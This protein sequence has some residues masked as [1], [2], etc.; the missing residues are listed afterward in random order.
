MRSVERDEY[1]ERELAMEWHD[2]ALSSG[3]SIPAVDLQKFDFVGYLRREI[4][5][6]WA[7]CG[8]FECVAFAYLGVS[9]ALIVLFAEN[10]AHPARLIGM[11]VLVAAVI[12]GLCRV[13]ARIAGR[14][15][16]G[17]AEERGTD[18]RVG[19]I[20]VETKRGTDKSVCPT[21]WHFWRHWY[22]HLYFLFCFEELG[23][24]VHLVRPG[25]EDAKLIAFD[26][27]LT[28]VHP[29]VWLEQFATP[30]RNDFMQFVYLTYFTYLL[31]VGGILY[32]RRDWQGYWAVMTYSAVGYAIG[33]VI[34]IFF[35][36]ESPWFSMA[37]A[38]HGELRGGA[39]T[40]VINFIEHY[41]RV[42]GAAFPSEHVAGA[43]AATWGAW[44]H[45]RW[46]F[47]V[48]LP[49]VVC[50]CVS[51]I[52]GRYHYVADIFGGMITGTL[53]YFIGGWLMERRRVC[54]TTGHST[55]Q[56]EVC[57]SELSG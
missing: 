52:W 42:R 30:G 3:E 22:P 32:Y 31:V 45:R 43:V 29:T 10:L 20:L 37:G 18:R 11:Q 26:H 5:A 38:W 36:I 17:G 35:P 28:G 55:A 47:W 21:L 57:A 50:M 8:V 56:T 2:G 34:A 12:L 51:T 13:E 9:S 46:L 41:G 27:W 16:L 7:A 1:R 24:L 40:S 49:L 48:M 33:Y 14:G 23:R 6:A 39:A 44:R 4:V 25:W 15:E 53:G 54:R 19:P